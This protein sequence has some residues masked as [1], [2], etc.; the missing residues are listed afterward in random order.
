MPQLWL[1]G[2]QFE[3]LPPMHPRCP[4]CGGPPRQAALEL[5]CRLPQIPAVIV[6]N[7]WYTGLVPGPPP[8]TTASHPPDAR[9]ASSRRAHTISVSAPCLSLCGSCGR[10]LALCGG[11]RVLALRVCATS[12]TWQRTRA[13]RPRLATSSTTRLS[14]TSSTMAKTTTRSAEEGLAGRRSAAQSGRARPKTRGRGVA[15][16]RRD[17]GACAQR[18]RAQRSPFESDWERRQ[19]SERREHA[20]TRID[21]VGVRDAPR[22]GHL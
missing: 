6:T 11:A 19:A 4:V 18:G 20:W 16:E 8:R 5:C 3:T 21:V 10:R 22:R 2:P 9:K 12:C 15:W 13:N 1:T 7:D 14:S 17:G